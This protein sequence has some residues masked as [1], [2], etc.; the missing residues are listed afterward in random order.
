[1]NT[2]DERRKAAA[3]SQTERHEHAEIARL[4]EENNYLV[5]R[6]AN[7]EHRCHVYRT[8]LKG[9]N[10]STKIDEPTET[11]AAD[12]DED[13]HAARWQKYWDTRQ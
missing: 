4:Q 12:D 5:Q 10:L 2:E 8:R 7:L 6:V 13:E 11:P 1:M 3:R 9:A